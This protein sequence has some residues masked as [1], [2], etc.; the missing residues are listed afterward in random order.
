MVQ[1]WLQ[2]VIRSLK[3][4][5]PYTHDKINITFAFRVKARKTEAWLPS[6]F[7]QKILRQA[8][9]DRAKKAKMPLDKMT[10]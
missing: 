3:Q 9:Q 2:E 4:A 5:T 1:D 10:F 6:F 8:A 7:A